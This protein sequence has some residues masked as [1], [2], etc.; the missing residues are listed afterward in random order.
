MLNDV[1][2]DA[3][4]KQ[5]ILNIF[6]EAIDKTA[7]AMGKELERKLLVRTASAYYDRTG[8]LVKAL[9]NPPKVYLSGNQIVWSLVDLNK[10]KQEKAKLTR[11]FNHHMNTFGKNSEAKVYNNKSLQ[12]WSLAN[13]DEGYTVLKKKKIPGLHFVAGAL[14]T[15]DIDYYLDKEL[16]KLISKYTKTLIIALQKGVK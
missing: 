16:N 9:M 7:Q 3:K 4:L 15:D 2:S 14:G 11:N 1:I 12:Y 8:D 6:Q 10:I 5:D 13:Q